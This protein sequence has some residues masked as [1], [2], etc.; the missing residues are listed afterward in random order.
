MLRT[1]FD[2]FRAEIHDQVA[3]DDKVVTRKTFYGKHSGKFMGVPPTN[4][5][6]ELGVI[7]ILRLAD[8]QFKEHWCQV[9]FAGLMQQITKN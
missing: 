3:E 2:E 1:A 8:G 9:D 7:D 5:A 4:R 6:I